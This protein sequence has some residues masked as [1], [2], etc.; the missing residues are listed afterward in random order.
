ML[1]FLS[2]RCRGGRDQP[3][4]EFLEYDP[5][6]KEKE[7]K[8]Y[9]F[10]FKPYFFGKV[11]D[12]M[13]NKKQ[14]EKIMEDVAIGTEIERVDAEFRGDKV[15]KIKT[16]TPSHTKE[17]KK[18]IPIETYESDV[19]Y[20]RRVMIDES[21]QIGI[22]KKFLAWDI[23]V[24]AREKVPDPE[25]ASKRIISIGAVDSEGNKFFFCDDDEKQ[26]VREF[27]EFA[28]KYPV[29]VGW[30]SGIFDYPYLKNRARNLGIKYDFFKFLNL[31]GALWYK[32]SLQK[33][34]PDDFGL[35]TVGQ[36]EGVGGKTEDFEKAGAMEKM[37]EF[38][39]ND[40]DRL[41][42]YNVEDAR[43]TMEIAKKFDTVK[44]AFSMASKSF[45][46]LQ[47]LVKHERGGQSR[48]RESVAVDAL[49]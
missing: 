26:M 40:R 41:R 9:K 39:K 17:L 33:Q 47:D 36:Y 13:E 49:I 16:P 24:D 22:P 46:R 48:I 29:C 35:D 32:D 30:Y 14:I 2:A 38:F 8:Q 1:M 18:R 12:Y 25:K 45:I 5:E 27:L 31:D 20:V 19:P 23:E 28:E 34:D 42:E 6:K 10:P 4:L 3:R 15:L 43:I 44:T 21:V 11:K 7:V 37:W